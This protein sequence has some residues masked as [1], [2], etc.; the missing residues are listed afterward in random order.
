ML[1]LPD[2]PPPSTEWLDY[3][4]YYERLAE[5]ELSDH[6]LRLWLQAWSDIRNVSH[7]VEAR[8]RLAAYAN[9]KDEA[10]QKAFE[11]YSDTLES[12]VQEACNRLKEKYLTF[13]GNRQ[14]PS[15]LE[16]MTLTFRAEVTLYCHT[17]KEVIVEH[18]RLAE[19]YPRITSGFTIAL[20]GEVQPIANAYPRLESRDRQNREE[21]WRAVRHAMFMGAH[22]LD[23]IYLRLLDYR[24]SIARNA[25]FANYLEYKW[26]ELGRFNYGP[27]D[28]DAFACMVTDHIIPL[29]SDM[30]KRRQELLDI[31]VLRPWDLKVYPFSEAVPTPFQNTEDM[32]D[33]A[34]MLLR[35]ITPDMAQLLA[36]I[37]A[38]GTLDIEPRE[39]KAYRDYSDYDTLRDLPI[40]FS[41]FA[42]AIQDFNYFI[43][44]CGH[45]FHNHLTM[46]NPLYWQRWAALEV[47]ELA[48]QT[49]ELFKIP[50]MTLLFEHDEVNKLTFLLFERIADDI[51]L[52]AILERFQQWVY[53]Q[54]AETLSAEILDAK[55]LELSSGL[56]VGV[57][58]KGLEA[59]RKKGWHRLHVF[60][61]PL[62]Q[63]EY[64]IA[65]VGALDLYQ[66]Y[67]DEPE[68]TLRA[69][70]DALSLGSTRSM[71]DIYQCAGTRF[72]I[73]SEIMHAVVETMRRQLLTL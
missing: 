67:L 37:R 10:A 17:N 26:L 45:A 19:A 29:L 35:A 36:T 16:H 47:M 4:Q 52:A 71:P 66:Q 61:W 48:A 5:V 14:P 50:H 25:G 72:P 60:Q 27:A 1:K 68:T 2:L 40:L 57:S 31:E 28:S 22:E 20:D 7:S 64:G 23:S 65:W 56:T 18:D 34:E 12:R 69:L 11:S 21:A 38:Q 53:T 59:Y 15:D 43:H 70:T 13:L 44:E 9:L 33:Q 3:A 58:W 63:L 51:L 8:L 62:Y 55:F 49:T 42:G 32:L 24:Q 46:K 54:P 41:Y 30:R 39:G 6:N 73:T